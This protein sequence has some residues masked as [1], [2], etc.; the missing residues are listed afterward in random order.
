MS[1]MDRREFAA[2]AALGLVGPALAD[3]ATSPT[4]TGAALDSLIARCG[5]HLDEADRKALSARL[6]LNTLGAISRSVKLDWRDE[7]A[8][9]YPP[10][11]E[12]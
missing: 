4:M 12:E 2:L 6:A 3:E 1:A 11:P 8:F 10:A 7:P 5:K 9:V